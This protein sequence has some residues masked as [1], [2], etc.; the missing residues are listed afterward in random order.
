MRELQHKRDIEQLWQEK[1]EVYRMQREIEYEERRK[2]SDIE[3]F[4]RQAIE[5]EKQRLLREH[6]D[7]LT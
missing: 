4:K 5:E 3:S 6:A 7:I 2:A 1:L